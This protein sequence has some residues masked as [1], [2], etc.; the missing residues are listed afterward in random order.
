MEVSPFLPQAE[1][2]EFCTS[3]GIAIISQDPLSKNVHQRHELLRDLANEMNISVELLLF[4]WSM[5]KG[6]I[7]LVPPNTHSLHRNTIEEL[8]EPLSNDILLY[9]HNRLDHESA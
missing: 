2:V 7:T 9:M 6:Y 4:R 3:G 1:L 5:S 8:C